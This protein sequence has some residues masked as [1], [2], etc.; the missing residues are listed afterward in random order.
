[1][2][3]RLEDVFIFLMHIGDISLVFLMHVSDVFLVLVVN[4]IGLAIANNG[5][6]IRKAL[7]NRNTSR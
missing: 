3:R 5:V 7:E 2:I 1:M 4:P 6:A